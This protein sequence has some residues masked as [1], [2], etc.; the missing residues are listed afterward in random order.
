MSGT[1]INIIPAEVLQKG[2]P[3]GWARALLALLAVSIGLAIAYLPLWWAA[4]VLLAVTLMVLT[5][6]EPLVGL[7][8]LLLIGPTK[9]L[10]DYF[11]P[12]LPLDLGQLALIGT[13]GA[14]L[15][16]AVWRRRPVP[17]SPLSL[18]LFIFMGAAGLSVFQALSLGFALKELIK[19]AQ[20][21]LVMW[22]VIDLAGPR[23]W[24][25]VMGMILAAAAI[26]A[27]IGVWQFG[28]RGEGPEHFR[29]LGDRFYRAYGTFEQPNPYG[30]FIG[31]TL[32]L[33]LG[34]AFAGM[35]RWGQPLLDH[36]RAR[37]PRRLVD[38]ART[39]IDRHLLGWIG[40]GALSALLASALLMS[41]SRGAWLGFGAAIWVLLFA[42]PRRTWVGLALGLGAVVASLIA[43]RFHLLPAV[44][45]ERLT[46]F[47]EFVQTFDVR[48]V[49][50]TPQNYAVLER[51]AHWQAAQE[52][53]RYHLWLGVGLGNYEPVYPGYALI[54]WPQALGHA[55]NIYLNLLAET[56]IVGLVAYLALWVTIFWQTWLVTRRAVLWP[57]GI[58]V[59]LLGTWT[60]LSVH[61]LLDKLYVANLHLHIGALLGILSI[62]TLLKQEDVVPG[63]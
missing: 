18:P 48:G 62:L 61:G 50:I 34:L 49:D 1:V 29:I 7:G 38:L 35:E 52:M 36:W 57:R 24:G 15:L 51:L 60:H 16:H 55:H 23:R 2:W 5:L 43:L 58:A 31:L 13:L 21:L 56:G 26:Q 27:L 37:S 44:L 4:L 54:N 22:L 47:S 11:V 3:S 8:V 19:W 42:W 20:V 53:A 45:V 6:I 63:D 12:E 9:P 28:L 32:P 33:S 40:L 10:T 46:S 39:S 25:A 30:G 14:W 59:G 17:R 41:W